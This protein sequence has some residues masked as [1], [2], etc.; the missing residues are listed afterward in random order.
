MT[1][2]HTHILP[3]IDDGS[4]D[5]ETSA[6]MLQ[7]LRAQGVNSVVLTP[8][9]YG[10]V[11]SPREFL[12][13]RKTSYDEIKDCFPQGMSV[14]LGA[15]VHFSDTMASNE[16]SALLCIEGTRY[17][18]LELPFIK[19][20]GSL[21][22][23]KLRYFIDTSDRVPII[24]H[25]CRYPQIRKNPEILSELYSMGCLLQADAA[26]FVHP[27][28]RRLVYAAM[29]H[30]LVHCIGSDCHNLFDR[31]PDYKAAI[32][33]AKNEGYGDEIER[34]QETMRDILADREIRRN[35]CL[36]VKKVF[37]FYK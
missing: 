27:K 31:S 29:K 37:S 16:Q 32:D 25:F 36:P 14:R 20:W 6:G 1:D 7:M 18:L 4:Q 26:A 12:R 19:E 2:L 23:E 28:D 13:K 8:H 11:H 15:E 22:F 30:N 33:D 9:Y 5:R 35:P 10:R 24:A 21:L 17:M 34:I 3:R